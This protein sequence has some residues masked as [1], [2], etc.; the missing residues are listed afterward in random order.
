VANKSVIEM[1]AT[2][3]II[4]AVIAVFCTSCSTMK[5]SIQK[6]NKFTDKTIS[7][8]LEKNGNV[9]YLNSTYIISSTVWTYNKG[10]I[11]IYKLSKG[12]VIEHLTFPDKGV[13]NYKIPVFEELQLEIKECGYELDGDGFGYRIKRGSEIHKQDLPIDIKCFT[14][15]KY[16]SEF[17][18][19]IVEDI[20]TY[21]MWDVRYE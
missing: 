15:L 10:N 8:L 20:N 11:E 6:N 17:S 3:R 7:S 12:K 13:S 18:N 1:K 2:I 4:L 21:K 19:K 5:Q 14:K 9:F 16:K